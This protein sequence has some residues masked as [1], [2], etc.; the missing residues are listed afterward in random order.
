MDQQDSVIVANKEWWEKMIA[1]KNGFTLP[2]LDLD[3]AAIG[4]KF[5]SA[6]PSELCWKLLRTKLCLCY[7]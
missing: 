7:N 1:E 6:G 2:W 3:P 4:S 5:Y